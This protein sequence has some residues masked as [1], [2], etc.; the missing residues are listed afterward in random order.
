MG[1]LF[2]TATMD[3]LGKMKYS[4]KE[5]LYN[6]KG[7]VEVPA[8]EMDEDVVDVQKCVVDALKSNAVVN[9]FMEHKKLTL[10]QSKCHKIHCGK[11]KMMCPELEV[12]KETMHVTDEEKY[13]GDHIN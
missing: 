2:C 7:I 5:M 12:H 6:Y 9:S 4:N 11:K 1:S 3:K 8:L 10:S 13:L